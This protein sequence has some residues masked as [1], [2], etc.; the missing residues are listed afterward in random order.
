VSLVFWLLALRAYLTA[1]DAGSAPRSK[2][3]RI[4]SYGFL[5]LSLL[6]KAWGMTF[7]LTLV[8]IDVYPLRR[9]PVGSGAVT[10][11]R[12]RAVWR[13]KIP[14]ALLGAAAGAGAWL[15]QRV[16]PD[17]MLSTAEWSRTARILQAAYGLCFYVWKTVWPTNLAAMYELPSRLEP[18]LT[19]VFVACLIAVIIGALAIV[20]TARRHP[21]F[22]AAAFAYAVTVAPVLGIAQSGPQL[23]ADRYAYVSSLAFS[24]IAAG[25]LLIL[26]RRSWR[27]AAAP[28]MLC[29]VVLGALTWKQTEVWHDSTTLWSHAIETGHPSYVAYVNYGQAVRAEGHLD[30]AI[31]S[32]QHAVAIRP[33]AGNGWYNLANSLKAEGRNDEAERAYLAAIDHLSWKVDAQ[34]NLGNLYFAR[35]QLPEAIRQYRAATD[36]LARVPAA[37]FTPEPYLYLGI[38]LSDSGDRDGARTALGV[39]LRYPA[40]RARAEAEL[41]R[42]ANA[43]DVRD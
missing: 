23:V 30:E 15:A 27:R 11:R 2:R 34:V 12:Y 21:E 37:E 43:I 29:L 3:W 22:M 9:L 18:G 19:N 17:T 1:L 42:I 40:T 20:V 26:S 10:D 16:Q 7:F 14:Y 24:A 39:A 33:Q 5:T 32:Y 28:A 41:R 38:A 13:E 6:A 25:G 4:L 31:A 8:A 36:T 35:H